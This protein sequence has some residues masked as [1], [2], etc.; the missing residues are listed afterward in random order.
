MVAIMDRGRE[1]GLH[2]YLHGSIDEVLTVLKARRTAATSAG[3]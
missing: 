2:H 1:L 3:V